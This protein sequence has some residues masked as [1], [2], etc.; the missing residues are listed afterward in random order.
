M[1]EDTPLNST[2]PKRAAYTKI[3]AMIVAYSSSCREVPS[4]VILMSSLKNP[5]IESLWMRNDKNVI[6]D[7]GWRVLKI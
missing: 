1:P 6:L 2:T 4:P 5:A 3:S 7:C